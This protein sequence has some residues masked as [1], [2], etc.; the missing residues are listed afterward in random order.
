M[1]MP[2]RVSV[3]SCLSTFESLCQCVYGSLFCLSGRVSVCL[4]VSVFLSVD[5]SLFV[6]FCLSVGACM[7]VS[8]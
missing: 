8:L 4:C 5:V 1:R 7:S 6:S 2:A 3:S